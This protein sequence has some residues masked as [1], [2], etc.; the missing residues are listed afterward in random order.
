MSPTSSSISRVTGLREG[1]RKPVDLN[2]AALLKNR[3]MLLS[4]PT[5]PSVI[6]ETTALYVLITLYDLMPFRVLAKKLSASGI[7]FLL[8]F[9][10]YIRGFLCS[11]LK[12]EG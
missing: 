9:M 7:D 8:G 1:T 4:L 5:S 6:R 10:H 2:T 3:E 12:L 11:S